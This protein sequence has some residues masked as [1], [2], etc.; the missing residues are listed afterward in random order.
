MNSNR[1]IVHIDMDAFFASV[2]Q[3]DNPSLKGKP[4]IVGGRPDSRGV[5]A[6]CSYEARKFGVRSAMSAAKAARLCPQAVFT[7]PRMSRYQEI[8]GIIM[9]IF[10]QYTDLVEQLSVDEAYLDLTTNTLNEPSASLMAERIRRR[11]YDRTGLTASAGVSCNKFLAKVATDINKPNGIT[12]IAPSQ[13][14]DFLAALPIGRFYG[15]GAAT[16]K[17]MERIGVKNGGDL[18]KFSLEELTFHFG[19]S[20]RYFFD[21]CRG[22]DPRPVKSSYTRK[23]IGNETTF[24][25]DILD[26]GLIV[27]VLKE[28]AES[29]AKSLLKRNTGG[30][31]LTLKVRY[32][33]FTTITRSATFIS[34]IFTAEDIMFCL[35]RLLAST[36]AGRRKVRLLG[37]TVSGLFFKDSTPVQLRLPFPIDFSAGSKW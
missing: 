1:K 14:L 11:I 4:V 24:S 3:L 37:V 18:K 23:S 25:E 31:T 16:E 2:E 5:V 17:K 10:S 9:E 26:T 35:P 7:R 19:K 22:Q 13:V 27:T 8:S 33:D 12:I 29:V 21:I 28:L 34:P 15:V 36:E 20:G 32:D 6:A 30:Y